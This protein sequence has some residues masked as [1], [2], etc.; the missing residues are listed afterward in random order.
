MEKM[1]ALQIYRVGREDTL[2][3]AESARKYLEEVRKQLPE[4]VIV[5]I[6]NDN[7][8]YL[9]G[10]LD[11]LRKNALWGLLLV[12]IILSLF[13]RPSLAVL[14][15]VG[16]PVSFAG[17]IWMMPTT[18]ISINM[19]TLFAFILV[20][21]IVVDDAIVV[22]ENVYRRIRNGENPR[23]ASWKGTHEVGV[24]VIFGV[25]TTAVAFTPTS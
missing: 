14:V 25:L 16:I 10:R 18:G 9:Q 1:R 4:G 17:A 6:W 13:L 21:G 8:Q 20:L 22:G 23:D 11:L 12:L 19:I 5:E 24:V 2:E 3:V 15:T 7:S